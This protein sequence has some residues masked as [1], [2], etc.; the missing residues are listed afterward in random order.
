MNKRSRG[1]D[2]EGHQTYEKKCFKANGHLPHYMPVKKSLST[3]VIPEGSLFSR[4]SLLGLFSLFSR[5]SLSGRQPAWRAS[6]P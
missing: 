3:Q 1:I 4:F 5:F 6:S 2:A